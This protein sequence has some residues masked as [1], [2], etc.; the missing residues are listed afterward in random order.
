MDSTSD[1]MIDELTKAMLAL[2]QDAQ[3]VRSIARSL[4]EKYRIRITE[5]SLKAAI[6]DPSGIG[7][8]GNF[9]RKATSDIDT[10]RPISPTTSKG[11]RWQPPL[12]LHYL[13]SYFENADDQ[14]PG[15]RAAANQN[16]NFE[17]ERQRKIDLAAVQ[18]C[19]A[20][21]RR[22]VYL[23]VDNAATHCYGHL[24]GDEL[25]RTNHIWDTAI[26][27][28]ACPG[29]TASLGKMCSQEARDLKMVD[30]RWP[31][32]RTFKGRAVHKE[33][34]DLTVTHPM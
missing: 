23:P 1:H 24:F 3:S 9:L 11:Y 26:N 5:S 12:T 34:L 29:C 8:Y 15:Y 22:P 16:G 17:T 4:E 2:A 19:T 33:R 21:G 14:D 31:R 13:F 30:G 28:Y 25:D 7:R 10:D 27:A 32:I 6:E 18:T 20:C